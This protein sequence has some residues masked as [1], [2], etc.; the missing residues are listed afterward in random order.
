MYTSLL[1]LT[2]ISF[3]L[4]DVICQPLKPL[5]AHKDCPSWSNWMERLPERKKD[6]TLLELTLPASSHAGS[7]HLTRL[8][9]RNRRIVP[10]CEAFMTQGTDIYGQLL[11]G[12]RFLQLQI[13]FDGKVWRTENTLY[14][15][16]LG[17]LL[18]Q[19]HK[20]LLQYQSEIVIV[21]FSSVQDQN[22]NQI[23]GR[24]M[25]QL[26]ELI[27]E[28]L[29]PNMMIPEAEGFN[30]SIRD[31]IARN[32]RCIVQ[33]QDAEVSAADPLLWNVADH[34]ADYHTPGDRERQVGSYWT[35]VRR[36][37]NANMLEI[38]RI[39]YRFM[40]KELVVAQ[41]LWML[42]YIELM[43]HSDMAR[44]LALKN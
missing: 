20:F 17:R 6:Q 32:K 36:T 21:S 33:I 43:P 7:Y 37:P 18:P 23:Y 25:D 27:R 44:L 2:G 9:F 38:A 14:G 26:R 30:T 34:I 29:D 1:L 3:S 22:G 35:A 13:V 39:N 12:A 4:A 41:N 31:L 8:D 24:P 15:L 42:D 40:W 10:S 11:S 5:V 16:P 19:I 28:T